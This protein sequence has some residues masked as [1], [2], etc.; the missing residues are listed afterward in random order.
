MSTHLS[1]EP[2]PKP[3]L[4]LGS[5]K[6]AMATVAKLTVAIALVAYLVW[7]GDIAWKPLRASLGEWQFTV[8]ALLALGLTPLGQLWRWQSL[9]RASR[10]RLPHREV[11]S[12]L[13]VAKFFN[14]ALPGYIGGDVIRGLYIAR[15]ASA[16]SPPGSSAVASMGASAVVPSILFDRIAGLLPLFALCLAGTLVAPADS[17]PSHL[18]V[19]ARTLS[20]TGLLAALCTFLLANRLPAA[21]SFLLRCSQRLRMDHIFTAFYK[22]TH[23]YVRDWGLIRN[24]LGI[25]LLSQALILL[26]FVLYGQALGLRL[27]LSSYLVLVPLGLLVTAIPIAP[28]GLGVGQV[29]FLALFQTAGTSQGANLITL[30]MAS[31]ALINLTGA[32][33]YPFFRVRNV[34]PASSGL[35][36]VERQ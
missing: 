24:V 12:Y 21:P 19:P 25:S 1:D 31:Q 5:G 28:G 26:G 22:G 35:A 8:P 3:S 9:L 2:I 10:V 17:L 33:L 20:A 14:M 16:T 6:N 29:A 36:H 4:G 34:L 23:L 18:V 13:M 11:F 30:Y 7:R 32:F 27:P 15:R